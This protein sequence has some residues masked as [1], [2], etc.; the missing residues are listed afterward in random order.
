MADREP[1]VKALFSISPSAPDDVFEGWHL[2]GNHW[3]GFATP[4]FDR[5]NAER[6]IA[7][8]ARGNDSLASSEVLTTFAWEGDTLIQTDHH[9]GDPYVERMEP[10]EEGRY[11]I[12]AGSW[13]W[14]EV[15]VPAGRELGAWLQW[16]N[17]DAHVHI[18]ANNITLKWVTVAGVEGVELHRLTRTAVR[19]AQELFTAH[20]PEDPH[21]VLGREVVDFLNL[22]QD[23]GGPPRTWA[24]LTAAEREQVLDE[25]VRVAV[26]STL[27][28]M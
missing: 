17:E 5:A 7:W 14:E 3:N 23:Q 13:T 15:Q 19:L 28:R 10:G 18:R 22:A 1:L 21:E 27:L 16:G 12:G 24:G 9:H 6:V 8:V 11:P 25:V 20:R 4:A 26:T 2:S